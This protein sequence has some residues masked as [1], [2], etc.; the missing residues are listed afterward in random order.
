MSSNRLKN[1]Y[2]FFYNILQF[3]SFVTSLSNT[4]SMHLAMYYL[5]STPVS[6]PLS[7]LFPPLPPFFSISRHSILYLH[8][9]PATASFTTAA[10]Q[11]QLPSVAPIAT[12][13]PR[14]S[15]TSVGPVGGLGVSGRMSLVT[16]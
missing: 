13:H 5:S 6:S 11:P 14:Q 9:T 2:F 15:H 1:H 4:F 16:Q 10:S 8:S 12:F 3:L 7:P